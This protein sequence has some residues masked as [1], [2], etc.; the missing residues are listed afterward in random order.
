MVGLSA[1][2]REMFPK[3]LNVMLCEVYII[4]L[5]ANSQ[6]VLSRVGGAE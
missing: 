2:Y 5:N 1:N 3:L 4:N 6:E